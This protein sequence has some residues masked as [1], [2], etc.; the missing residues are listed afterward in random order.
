MRLGVRSASC[1]GRPMADT[2]RVSPTIASGEAATVARALDGGYLRL[3]DEGG[4][5]LAALR[6]ANPAAASIEEGVVTF[7]SLTP[8]DAVAT[9]TAARFGAFAADGEDA[10]W[11][12]SVGT[13]DATLILDTTAIERHALVYVESLHFRVPR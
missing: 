7:A 13:S 2:T 4:V 10:V 1:L 11:T 5:E 6:F 12:G 9:G 3:F 8:A